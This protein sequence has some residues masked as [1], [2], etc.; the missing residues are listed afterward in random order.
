MSDHPSGNQ[1][2]LLLVEN[3]PDTVRLVTLIMVV[4]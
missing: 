3:E 1:P 4:G 2:A